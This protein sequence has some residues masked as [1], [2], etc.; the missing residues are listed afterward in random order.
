MPRNVDEVELD[1]DML[2]SLIKRLYTERHRAETVL[3]PNQI[4]RNSVRKEE[5]T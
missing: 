3:E 4:G 5:A 2:A 1:A